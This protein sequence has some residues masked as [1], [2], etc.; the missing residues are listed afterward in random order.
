[1]K[2]KQCSIH[3]SERISGFCFE[4]SILVC[5][6]CVLENHVEHSKKVNSVEEVIEKRRD[7]VLNIGVK[8]E[9]RLKEIEEVEKRIEE[10]MKELEKKLER[11]RSEKKEFELEKNDLK[12]RKDSIV[13][14]SNTN[15]TNISLFF[16]QQLFSTLLQTAS[17]IVREAIKSGSRSGLPKKGNICRDGVEFISSFPLVE[18]PWGGSMN[19]EGT[20]FVATECSSLKVRDKEGGVIESVEEAIDL[21]Q[22]EPVDVAI[23]LNDQ[24]VL[25]DWAQQRYRVVI[26]DKEGELIRS[27]G[28]AGSQP[29]Q[30]DEP[31]GLS[32]DKEG[33]IIVADSGTHRIQIFN[34]EGC[35]IRSFDLADS[36]HTQSS[37]P[38]TVAVDPD[39]HLVISNDGNFPLQVMDIEGRL[40]RTAGS[41]QLRVPYHVDVDGKGRIVVTSRELDGNDPMCVFDN[42][43]TF[44][45]S[46][47]EG[48][49][50]RPHGVVVDSFGSIF[51]MCEEEIQVWG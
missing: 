50:E 3:P 49:V 24:I 5:F 30:F 21:L 20:L 2:M 34:H 6:R 10:E 18:R 35:F 38:F 37:E 17:E 26:L 51:V 13:R 45:F 29:G 41:S 33:R 36:W 22:L 32:V 19:S 7:E 39:G 28:S 42:D 40:I 27:F 11:K 16:D 43:G 25:L 44:L 23:G 4:C 1:M 46:F 47:G 8:L 31:W 15:P 9:N 48:R 14:L 12:M